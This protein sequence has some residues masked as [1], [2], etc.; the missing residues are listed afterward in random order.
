M[1]KIIE[2][3]NLTKIYGKSPKQAFKGIK[4]GLT[5][6]EILDTT[7][8]TV[9]LNN[10]S[11]EVYEG[12]TFVI[13]GLSGSG[14]STLI[15]CLNLIHRP[16]SGEIKVFDK[17]ITQLDKKSLREFRKN[18]IAMVFQHFGL[19]NHMNVIENVQFGLEIKKVPN[20]KRAKIAREA[21]DS[22]G[23][24]GYEES[25]I[26]DLSGGM[27]QRVGLARALAN[28]PDILLMDEP[29]SALDP[30]IKK[31]M[32]EELLDL[33]SK[34]KKTIIFITHDVNEAFKLG[35]RI[36]VLKD[37]ELIQIGTPNEFIENPANEYIKKFIE[38][39]DKLRV[40][41]CK[42]IM[43]KNWLK[44]YM[45]S[46]PKVAIMEM[47]KADKEIAV[48]VNKERDPIGFITLDDCIRA[49]KE[50]LELSNYIKTE[51]LE[52]DLDM[53]VKD[54][55]EDVFKTHYPIVIKNKEGK[56][57]G[58]IPRAKLLQYI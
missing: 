2:I 18:N 29:F 31:E 58:V 47:E 34:L 14:K 27:K 50:E 41:K 9:G 1:D 33:Q 48:A 3:N 45:N 24:S 54:I 39:V 23:L 25:D 44:V 57:V 42:D 32:H 19:F 15:R 6:E 16:T 38:D 52:V 46:K 56:M 22:V 36:A 10:I 51:F 55:M 21:I 37:G 43:K 40:L 49:K 30:L 5:K 4:E 53:Y 12:E 26:N 13:M 20:E 8:Q 7:G 35:D 17:D 11:F 28:D